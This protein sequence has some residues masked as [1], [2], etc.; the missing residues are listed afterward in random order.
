MASKKTMRTK[1]ALTALGVGESTLTQEET[2]SF[3]EQGFVVLQNAVSPE[4]LDGMSRKFE[5]LMAQE[6][7]DNG[8]IRYNEEESI[9]DIILK[10]FNKDSSHHTSGEMNE[11]LNLVN[12]GDVFDITYI[13]PKLLAAVRHALGEDLKVSQVTAREVLPQTGAPDEHT[14]HEGAFHPDAFIVNCLWLLDDFNETNGAL[15]VVVG[16]HHKN[17]QP[18]PDDRGLP[19][20]NLNAPAGSVIVLNGKLWRTDNTNRSDQNKRMILV[21][22]IARSQPQHTDQK[23]YIRISTYNRISDAAKYLLDL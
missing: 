16:S 3:D 21:N 1:E 2:R 18:S 8:R 9:A 17:S 13:Q 20:V 11:V 14:G 22:F 4:Q 12:E 7:Y 6:G 10:Q 15:S 5:K 19:V 23:T